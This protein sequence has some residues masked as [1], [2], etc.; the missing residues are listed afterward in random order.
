[1]KLRNLSLR[2]FIIANDFSL[3]TS[4]YLRF[5]ERKAKGFYLLKLGLM[6][7]VM[8]DR[9]NKFLIREIIR[10]F[11]F[12]FIIKIEVRIRKWLNTFEKTC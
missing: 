8:K 4:A 3:G 5:V 9:I 6:V 12:V 7:S 11:D 1:V 10:G 2:F